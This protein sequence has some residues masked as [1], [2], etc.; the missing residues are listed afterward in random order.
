MYGPFR[1]SRGTAVQTIQAILAKTSS[2]MT[3][4][5]GINDEFVLT[6]L[7]SVMQKILSYATGQLTTDH[8]RDDYGELLELTVMF[9]GGVPQEDLC[10]GWFTA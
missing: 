2:R 5:P 6:E 3:S 4:I 1:C 8:P 10:L 7:D 9:L